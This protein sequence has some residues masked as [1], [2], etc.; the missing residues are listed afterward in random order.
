[1]ALVADLHKRIDQQDA[2]LA[3]Q[4]TLFAHQNSLL[5]EVLD[6]L[7]VQVADGTGDRG[8]ARLPRARTP[9]GGLEGLGV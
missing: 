8:N 3:H 5:A 9:S 2:L 6:R 4:N 7:A 1:M